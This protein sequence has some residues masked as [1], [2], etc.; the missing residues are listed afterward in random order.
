[1]FGTNMNITEKILSKAAGKEKVVPGEVIFAKLDGLMGHD[2]KV[3]AFQTFEEKMNANKVFDADKIWIVFDH[4]VPADTVNAALQQKKLRHYIEKYQITHFYD[5]GQGGICHVVVP[6]KGLVKP[7]HVIIGGDSHTCTYG[8]L[9][10]FATGV[11]NTDFAYALAFGEVW[12]QVPS[13][14]K[15]NC[16]G[17]LPDYIGGKDIILNL[18]GNIGIAGATYK[19]LEFCGETVKSLSMADRFTICNMVVEAGAKNGIFIPDEITF[20]YLERIMPLEP[21][22]KEEWS[23]LKSDPDAHYEETINIDCSGL[24]PQVACPHLPD[25]VVNVE[26]L[27]DIKID[28]IFIGSC[29]NGRIEDLRRAAK[30]LKGK[31]ISSSL[32]LIVIPGSQLTLRQA[33]REGIW[34]TFLNAGAILGPPTC[35]PCPGADLGLLAAGEVALSVSNRNFRGRMGD[36]NSEVYLASPAVAAASALT[37]YITHPGEV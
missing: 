19:A 36:P 12:L 23:L 9:G 32:R 30:I 11:G 6:E 21:G 13:T 3:S 20:D 2:Q 25:N 16:A 14:I 18:L 15:V 33:I 1:M 35:G 17:S 37:G 31:K 7:G 28:Q 22:R 5:V 27:K 24:S 34:E 8:A 10:A 4:H 29:T 26:E